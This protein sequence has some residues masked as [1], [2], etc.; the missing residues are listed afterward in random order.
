MTA[1]TDLPARGTAWSRV[2]GVLLSAGNRAGEPPGEPNALAVL[3]GASLIGVALLALYRFQHEAGPRFV[4]LFAKEGPL[5]HL[6]F[7]LALLGAALC[8]GALWR[9]SR[10]GPIG[11][12]P[13]L[14]RWAFAA[15]GLVLFAF[16]MEEINWSQTL[17]GFA[18]PEGWRDVNLQQ[19][20]SLHNVLDRDELEYGVRILGLLLT[21]AVVAL[22]VARLRMP[23]SML[24]QI[25]PH[26]ALVPL[27]FCISYASIRQHSEVV[28]LMIAI[29]FA[30]YT[31]RLWSL[32]RARGR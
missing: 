22:T 16:G 10:R 12:P 13:R 7:M 18:T 11:A 25:A 19:E 28:E 3:T 26:P 20:T 8:A 27:A 29:F 31:Y 17:F 4:A 9:H 24:G 14:V 1:A 30:F 2:R 21:A 5:E 6:T 23:R 15:L 32:A